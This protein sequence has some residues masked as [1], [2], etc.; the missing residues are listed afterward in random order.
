VLLH[1]A[2]AIQLVARVEKFLVV[3]IADQFVEFGYGKAL[4]QIDLFES[5][6]S[7]AKETLRF[8]AGGSSRLEIEFHRLAS[9]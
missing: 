6:S 2:L 1:L 3:T 8:A 9:S 7:L 5:N 4:V